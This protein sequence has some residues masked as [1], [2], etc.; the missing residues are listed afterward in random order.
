MSCIIDGDL[1]VYRAAAATESAIDW[2][3]DLWTIS[4]D[5][6][7]AKKVWHHLMKPIIN[8]R[9][10]EIHIAFSDKTNFRKDVYP[11]YK[12]GRPRKPIG[13]V[14]LK[15]WVIEEYSTFVYDGLEGDDALGINSLK[16]VM[17]SDDKDLR[18]V[19]GKL[20]HPATDELVKTSRTEA[21]RFFFKQILTG[22]STDGYPGCPGVGDKRADAILEGLSDL[23]AMWE[24]VVKAFSSK[25]LTI[26]DALTQA[27]CAR[28]LR[29]KEYNIQ[30]KEVTLWQPPKLTVPPTSQAI[31]SEQP[32]KPSPRDTMK[33]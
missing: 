26:E 7:E 11:G 9:F 23:T 31:C 28:I 16:H 21:D 25:D 10:G 4:C 5:V 8:R 33:C 27:R 13:F 22:D 12:N 18:G 24:A 14:P 2:G 19:P 32:K 1:Y 20:Y 3:D 17:V 15:N 29:P 30:T 6:R